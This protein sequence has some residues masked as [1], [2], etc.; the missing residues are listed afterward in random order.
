MP[1]S[2]ASPSSFALVTLAAVTAAGCSSFAEQEDG[3]ASET[4]EA[5][6]T[7]CETGITLPEVAVQGYVVSDPVAPKKSLGVPLGVLDEHAPT[8]I[9]PFTMVSYSE[10]TGLRRTGW[11][12]QAKR[13][14]RF[15]VSS[16]PSLSIDL[17]VYGPIQGCHAGSTD[18]PARFEG[19][20]GWRAP[21]T[22]TYFV[23]SSHGLYRGAGG[24]LFTSPTPRPSNP[25]VLAMRRLLADDTPV[26]H[27]FVEATPLPMYGVSEIAVRKLAGDAKPALLLIGVKVPATNGGPGQTP[28]LVVVRQNAEPL[29]VPQCREGLGGIVAGDFDGD[30]R[31]DVLSGTNLFK[32]T[33][34]GGF[35]CEPSGLAVYG[36]RV[37]GPVDVDGDGTMDVLSVSFAGGGG[38]TT[39]SVVVTPYFHRGAGF[40][41]GANRRVEVPFAT[42][43]E[44][45]RA[46]F[47]DVTGDGKPEVVAALVGPADA[48]GTPS[49]PMHVVA[50]APPAY[51]P[52]D[53]TPPSWS[54]PSL[55]LVQV[56]GLA[57]LTPDPYE[58][59]N[60]GP[61]LFDADG[62]G[63]PDR[64]LPRTTYS[65]SGFGV[66]YG[67]TAPAPRGTF[68]TP[69]D[70]P[71]TTNFGSSN[72]IVEHL[73]YD[74]DGCEDVIVAGYGMSL[75]RG[76]RCAR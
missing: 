28:S 31:S 68:R 48:A 35:T 46:A 20:V 32:G 42:N 19:I 9:D 11:T 41:S 30:G 13:G 26:G 57:S 16:S 76:V 1:S 67:A 64:I 66:A 65:Y 23:T 36:G 22:G 56:A 60:R 55:P 43:A 40:V 14:E 38:S 17:D 6:Q 44:G 3:V 72:V 63:I 39:T 75:F 69:W 21:A 15:S 62:D 52:R 10:A 53:A 7:S 34:S 24:E 73:D 61:R 5:A 29:Y 4:S 18:A 2:L 51:D 27:A 70:V 8:S 59:D 12:F 37:M 45:T 47:L 50:F 49:G 25:G 58:L 71:S 33:A 74:G 54:A